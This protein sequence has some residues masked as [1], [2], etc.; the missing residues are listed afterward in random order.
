MSSIKIFKKISFL[1]KKKLSWL[2]DKKDFYPAI[3]KIKGQNPYIEIDFHFVN[4]S[5]DY[6]NFDVYFEYYQTGYAKTISL[7]S[8][9][10]LR[11][12]KK[13]FDLIDISYE[14]I[15]CS[16]KI[17]NPESGKI[18]AYAD[19]IKPDFIDDENK[20][21]KLSSEKYSTAS[22]IRWRTK[23]MNIPW[24]VN[25]QEGEKPICF[26]NSSINLKKNLHNSNIHKSLIHPI[27]FREILI[28][29]IVSNEINEEDIWRKK[30]IEIAENLLEPMP[31]NDKNNKIDFTNEV[32]KWIEDVVDQFSKKHNFNDKYS[33]EI[34]E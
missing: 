11:D 15:K 10:K 14:L 33:K 8:V 22:W 24:L 20:D 16:I 4:L 12:T 19:R 21:D 2:G 3:Y 7:G 1:G 17:V 25:V 27:I 5:K 13:K 29:Y 6:E 9:E 30:I 31:V 18:E 28:K 34:D 32:N 26:L 23:P